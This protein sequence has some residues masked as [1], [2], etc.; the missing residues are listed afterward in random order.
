[1]SD[2]RNGKLGMLNEDDD[3]D[4]DGDNDD[5]EDDDDDDSS[6]RLWYSF[7][8]PRMMGSR[9][10]I[11]EKEVAKI[12]KSW[13][14]QWSNLGPCGWKTEILAI[15]PTISSWQNLTEKSDKSATQQSILVLTKWHFSLCYFNSNM[16]TMSA[17]LSNSVIYVYALPIIVIRN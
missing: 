16:Y 15:A 13:Q 2:P 4:D 1:M 11:G 10:S 6:Q 9:V 8:Y 12:F 7:T 3:N 17:R 5:S 14:N